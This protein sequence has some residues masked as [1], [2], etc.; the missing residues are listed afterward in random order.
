MIVSISKPF[1]TQKHVLII[2]R[3]IE[4]FETK[5]SWFKRFTFW[6]SKGHKF[7]EKLSRKRWQVINFHPLFKKSSSNL[8][9]TRN[10]QSRFYI[11]VFVFETNVLFQNSNTQLSFVHTIELKHTWAILQV[12]SYTCNKGITT[13]ASNCFV[14]HTTPYLMGTSFPQKKGI[15]NSPHWLYNSVA[16]SPP[17]SQHRK[18]RARRFLGLWLFLSTPVFKIFI[19]LM[20]NHRRNTAP[21]PFAQQIEQARRVFEPRVFSRGS[22]AYLGF[23]DSTSKIIRALQFMPVSALCK[24]P[25]EGANSDLM[26]CLYQVLQQLTLLTECE[27][28]HPKAV[29]AVHRK[30][31]NTL[32]N[33]LYFLHSQDWLWIRMTRSRSNVRNRLSTMVSGSQRTKSLALALVVC[34]SLQ[35]QPKG[36]TTV[37]TLPNHLLSCSSNSSN[38]TR[39]FLLWKLFWKA[40]S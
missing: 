16:Y 26:F 6:K 30:V 7:H 5:T 37:L 23:E 36:Q 17:M 33:H 38:A 29:L 15:N 19:S 20:S 11:R 9:I 31:I 32:Y 13:S 24:T 40:K 27:P 8:S 21:I 35:L 3:D 12:Q 10:F 39:I 2:W 25:L 1:L 34:S 18:K 4:R 28:N 22:I 14:F